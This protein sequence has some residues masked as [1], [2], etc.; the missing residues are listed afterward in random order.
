MPSYSTGVIFLNGERFSAA[1][2]ILCAEQRSK[3]DV[4]VFEPRTY[5]TT[6]E[7]IRVSLPRSIWALRWNRFSEREARRKRRDM[8]G[9]HRR[10]I[11]MGR[12]QA[13]MDYTPC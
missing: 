11:V 8:N 2:S 6:L 7:P 1:T 13:T 10:W 4:L 5:A 3:A 9:W 12:Y